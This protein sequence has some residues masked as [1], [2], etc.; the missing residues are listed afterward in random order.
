MIA[1]LCQ[2]KGLFEFGWEKHATKQYKPCWLSS[3]CHSWKW[4]W[5]DYGYC[6]WRF[7][8]MECT[9]YSGI[10]TTRGISFSCTDHAIA[11]FG[12]W[13][14]HSDVMSTGNPQNQDT[15][16][17]DNLSWFMT[18]PVHPLRSLPTE[19]M[20]VRQHQL[21]LYMKITTQTQSLSKFCC[22]NRAM[23]WFWSC[24]EE[25]NRD[26]KVVKMSQ[27]HL[28]SLEGI[29][30]LFSWHEGSKDFYSSGEGGQMQ[31]FYEKSI[32]GTR[33]CYGLFWEHCWQSYLSC[34]GQQMP[35]TKILIAM[36]RDKKTGVHPKLQDR[37]FW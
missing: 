12:C 6:W 23:G 33:L 15:Y 10:A 11:P 22:N 1:F 13:Y 30:V 19:C 16:M 18:R 32:M 2:Q 25:E 8:T 37:V 29:W 28:W 24:E 7:C 34:S 14:S 3:S 21:L 31:V 27:V 36:I 9:K 20:E 4:Y 17:S 35:V 5:G 26:C